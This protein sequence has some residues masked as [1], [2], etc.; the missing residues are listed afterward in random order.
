MNEEL[1]ASLVLTLA[2]SR[3]PHVRER[4]SCSGNFVRS[5][6]SSTSL[7]PSSPLPSFLPVKALQKKVVK[8]FHE[9]INVSFGLTNVIF[10]FTLTLALHSSEVP[11][12]G[13]Q[14]GSSPF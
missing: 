7:A 2:P 6:R 14:R 3:S 13:F 9:Y 10:P 4:G 5:F 12:I 8:T 1:T 11:N